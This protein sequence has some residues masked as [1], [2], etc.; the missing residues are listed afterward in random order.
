[1]SIFVRRVVG[2]LKGGCDLEIG[3]RTLITG[4]NGSGKS[5][6]VNT[7]ELALSGFAS[8][9]V[10]RSELRQGADLIALAPQD[11]HLYAEVTM[12]DDKSMGVYRIDRKKKG[13]TGRPIHTPPADLEV[14]YPIRDVLKA[15]RGTVST[16]RAFVLRHSGLDVT[17]EAIVER[18]PA[19]YRD[20]YGTFAAAHTDAPNAIERLLVIRDDAAASS[21][22]AVASA[23]ANT[24][25]LNAFGADVPA[26]KPTDAQIAEAQQGARLA[27]GVYNDA[28]NVPE[29][30]DVESLRIAAAGAIE[31]LRE[32]EA[33]VT[34]LRAAAANG[35]AAN[36]VQ[37][38]TALVTLLEAHA[39]HSSGGVEDCLMCG[40][41]MRVDPA[42]L[43][44]RASALRGTLLNA[45]EAI[46]AQRQLG[47]AEHALETAQRTAED[48]VALFQAAN[49]GPQLADA[50][51]AGER[52]AAIAAAYANLTE[53][54]NKVL[55][56]TEAQVTWDKV[57]QAR[58]LL[59]DAEREAVEGKSLANACGEVIDSLT[60]DGRSQFVMSVNE[61][62]PEGDE[63]DL[64]LQAGAR[65]VC[66]F[67]L[68]R[69]GMLHTALSGAEWARLTLALGAA[70]IPA[71]DN[72]LAVLTPEERAYD[73]QTLSAVMRALSEAPG[74]VVITSP[75][76]PR[77][78]T[79]KGWTVIDVEEIATAAPVADPDPEPAPKKKPK[80][81]KKATKKASQVSET[82]TN[83]SDI[84]AFLADPQPKAEA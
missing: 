15:L 60:E 84:A 74:Q 2:N 24:T 25:I 4:P 47:H 29:A 30:P 76:K 37:L 44:D 59:A 72:V 62:L 71:G 23:K 51:A 21:R 75:V 10:G 68:R 40:S 56:L 3:P 82:P 81:K 61:F 46:T 79:P 43:R 66:S 6:I 70:T 36:V 63:F 67:G 12:S 9:I 50:N 39:T 16:A 69:D 7:L 65:E 1:V 14:V 18:L 45:Q 20:L 35:G 13:A 52:Q 64:V 31:S 42:Q 54:E 49:T 53:A 17:D 8:D 57:Q 28:V 27:T 33:K 19:T 26:L 48:A 32:W 58:D 11:D 41:Q 83:G 77:G 38:R 73:G 78:R 5:R 55:R 22:A 34:A 80:L